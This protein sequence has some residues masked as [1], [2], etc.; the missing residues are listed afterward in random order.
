M[1]NH[2][3]HHPTVKTA[4]S[5]AISAAFTLAAS[6]TIF[7]V[8]S[9]P[10][11][12]ASRK[13]YEFDYRVTR[14]GPVGSSLFRRPIKATTVHALNELKRC[15]NCSFPVKGAPKTYP[16]SD[17]QIPL[18][19]CAKFTSRFTCKP[20]PVKA[21]PFNSLGRLLL[22][23]Q[24]GHF[25]GANSSVTFQFYTEQKTGELKLKVVAYVTNPTIPDEINKQSADDTWNRF[26]RQLGDNMWANTCA[27]GK[28]CG[29]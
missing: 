6:F 10:A 21:Y 11:H 3:V 14:S 27:K 25:D 28:V 12:A 4:G 9:L 20:A 2:S 26:A 5:F 8:F 29:K 13:L 23:A 1:F 15:F 7:S 24:R 19:A 17:Q 22:I 16:K 18:K